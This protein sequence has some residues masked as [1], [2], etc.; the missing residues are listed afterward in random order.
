[1]RRPAVT[2]VAAVAIVASTSA[3]LA[4]GGFSDVPADH[5]FAADISWLADQGITKGCNPP[6]NDMFCPEDLVTRA[7]MAAFM[8]RF[9]ES[10]LVQGSQGPPG[11]TGPAGPTGPVGPA[12]PPGPAGPAPILIDIDVPRTVGPDVTMLDIFEGLEMPAVCSSAQAFLQFGIGANHVRAGGIGTYNEGVRPVSIANNAFFVSR[13][14]PA[15][16]LHFSG[17][18]EILDTG[19]IYQVEVHMFYGDPCTVWGTAIPVG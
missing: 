7:Q 14:D 18:L 4:A 3:A 19:D 5:T 8:R 17:V 9:A 10:D 1:M 16:S 15:G 13:D 2:I 12:G 11:S 6:T